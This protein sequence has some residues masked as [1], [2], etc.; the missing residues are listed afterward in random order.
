[1]VDWEVQVHFRLACLVEL[2]VLLAPYRLVLFVVLLSQ[3][4][5]LPGGST[6]LAASEPAQR[7]HG[8]RYQVAD[9]G[10]ESLTGLLVLDDRDEGLSPTS[11][12]DALSLV[13]DSGDIAWTTPGFG[14]CETIGGVHRLAI[15]PDRRRIY[16]AENLA[17]RVTA[18]DFAGR[19]RLEI[20]G[21][22]ASAIAVDTQW[23]HLWVSAGDSID[24]GETLIFDSEGTHLNTLPFR[25]IDLVKIP[26]ADGFWMSGTHLNRVQR[27]EGSP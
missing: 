1:M 22:D 17:R 18:L 15:D 13:G 20:I 11:M 7:F 3:I 10:P 25:G 19:R 8:R 5:V 21:M 9:E 4:H 2:R 23:G 16:V 6:P 27:E 24:A 12:G 14:I 26:N